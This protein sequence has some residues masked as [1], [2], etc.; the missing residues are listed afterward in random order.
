MSCLYILEI[1]S[2]PIA[3]FANTF[4]HS[5]GCPFVLCLVSFVVL[6]IYYPLNLDLSFMDMPIWMRYLVGRGRFWNLPELELVHWELI[7]RGVKPTLVV[8]VHFYTVNL[9]T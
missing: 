6:G 8:T 1:N 7:H 5:E 9:F 3:S 2:L 4:Y